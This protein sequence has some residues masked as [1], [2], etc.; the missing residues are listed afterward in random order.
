MIYV[1]LDNYKESVTRVTRHTL[2]M[3]SLWRTCTLGV[4]VIEELHMIGESNRNAIL[5]CFL[6]VM[7]FN[8]RHIV[9]S[10]KS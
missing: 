10:T 6:K 9:A 1:M 5:Q 7:F 3:R 4:I 8:L 2:C